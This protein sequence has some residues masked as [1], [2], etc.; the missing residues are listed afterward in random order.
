MAD[1]IFAE[2]RLARIYDP[3]D[4]DRGDLEAYATMVREFGARRVLDIGCGTGTFA[5]LLA[6][7]GVDV[8]A[9]DPAAASLEVARTKVGADRVRWVHGYATDLPPLQVD[10]ATMT[11]N[12][13]QVFLTDDDWGSTLL[14]AYAALRPGGRLVFETRD[15]TA[16]AWLEWNR[17][18]SHQE[19]IIAGV[20]AVETW[21]DVVDVSGDL[22]SFR[23]TFVFTSD[24]ATL[25]SD[26]T[27]R[28][29][30][31][32]QVTASL[33]AAGF[34]VGEVRQAPDRPGREMVFVAQRPE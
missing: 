20:G 14:A 1:P 12:V 31:R 26:S 3:L 15:P 33:T 11:A 23:W 17:D 16:K 22:V 4:P 6:R 27:L 7:R 28:F 18:R 19:T 21:V 24:G 25:T 5:C 2:R 34:L 8:T 32:D 9:V 13:A 30:H 10:L 29:R